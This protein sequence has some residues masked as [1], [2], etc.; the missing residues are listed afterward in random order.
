MNVLLKKLG[1]SINGNIK[2]S[3]DKSISIRLVI[4][5][6]ILNKN[7]KVSNLNYCEDTKAAIQCINK[8]KIINQ[9]NNFKNNKCVILNCKNS[10]TTMRLLSGVLPALYS[11]KNISFILKGDSSLS[12]RPMKRII[13]PLNKMGVDIKSTNNK[14]TPPL[15]INCKD[16]KINNLTYKSNISSG[17]VKSSLQ[18]AAFISNKKLNYKEPYESR[19]HTEIMLNYITNNKN[20]KYLVPSDISTASFFITNAILY[21]NSSITLNNILFNKTRIKYFETLIKIGI[22][23]KISNKKIINGEKIATI[24]FKS[25]NN[26][27]ISPINIKKNDIPK[28]IDELPLLA[29]IL[30]FANGISS[31]DGVNE[32]KYKE[33]NRLKAIIDIYKL[34]KIK[35]NLTNDKLTIYGNQNLKI[36]E[37][38]KIINNKTK[39]NSTQKN[40]LERL[41]NSKDHRIL[42]LLLI[43]GIK[44][45]KN[46]KYLSISF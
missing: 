14:F 16:S 2:L 45:I 6:F 19:N 1:K 22:D 5:A 28:M 43:L 3:G 7:M 10:A 38:N 42:I 31:I 20:N 36:E 15:I 44:K 17:Q 13:K 41:K 30:I 40:S 33:S 12:K 21:K 8:L 27:N 46:K 35:Y 4:I 11:N 18:L 32:L 34:L 26:L 25:N 39:L 24:K 29:I 23:I 9:K 37:I